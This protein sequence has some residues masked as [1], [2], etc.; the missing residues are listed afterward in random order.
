MYSTCSAVVGAR[1]LLGANAC[2]MML[3]DIQQQL[4][5]LQQSM[6]DSSETAAEVQQLRHQN[7]ELDRCCT[8]RLQVRCDSSFF[9]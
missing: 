7:M 1:A 2:V 4:E 5:E 6:E 8:P 9:L 3:Q